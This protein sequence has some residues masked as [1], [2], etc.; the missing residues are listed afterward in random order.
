MSDKVGK[1]VIYSLRM[2]GWKL[3]NP[4]DDI[5]GRTVID[6]NG[7][8]MGFVDDL[9]LD[10]H[11]SRI[12]FVQIAHGGILGISRSHFLTPVNAITKIEDKY[13]HIDRTREDVERATMY[14]PA[15]VPGTD[16]GGQGWWEQG[17]DGLPGVAVQ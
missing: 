9:L 5:R 7:E 3:A 14:K 16:T 17:P 8:K 1:A 4:A 11:D 13:V 6:R 10:D 12:R 15:L 2:S